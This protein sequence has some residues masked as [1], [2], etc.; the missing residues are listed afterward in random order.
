MFEAELTAFWVCERSLLP[1]PMRPSGLFCRWA[2]LTRPKPRPTPTRPNPTPTQP[3]LTQPSTP[4][5]SH[6]PT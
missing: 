5:Q 4:A 3:N 2:N 1:R 6:H